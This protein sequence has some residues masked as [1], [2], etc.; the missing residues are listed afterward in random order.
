MI[1]RLCFNDEMP[2]VHNNRLWIS[3][4]PRRKWKS[5]FEL[6][7]VDVIESKPREAIKQQ[8]WL[9]TRIISIV[10]DDF[11]TSK[12]RSFT[13]SVNP[14]LRSASQS[15]ACIVDA[16][17][18]LKVFCTWPDRSQTPTEENLQPKQEQLEP[19]LV[20][21]ERF[22]RL[23]VKHQHTLRHPKKSK[24]KESKTSNQFRECSLSDA[25]LAWLLLL[26]DY[27]IF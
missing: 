23:R 22:R 13:R 7:I 17:L 12:C 20:S 14:Q 24:N 1:P 19:T 27:F 16:N 25:R 15:F 2:I 6:N 26:A 9:I 3:L 21:E 10:V 5:A 4:N 11:S 18:F 8:L